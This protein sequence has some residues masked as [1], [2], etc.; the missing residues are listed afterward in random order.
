MPAVFGAPEY[1]VIT[2]QSSVANWWDC[3]R[4]TRFSYTPC[5]VC[6]KSLV[7][8]AL[9]SCRFRNRLR[10]FSETEHQLRLKT[11]VTVYTES[12]H[13]LLSG[14]SSPINQSENPDPDVH[15]HYINEYRS[16]ETNGRIYGENQINGRNMNRWE[17]WYNL[18]N[19]STKTHMI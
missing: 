2:R 15:T 3:R 10:S 13:I 16:S 19:R 17:I 1:V 18:S 11:G 4:F 12:P 6:R 7:S 9:S 14:L 8:V 5:G